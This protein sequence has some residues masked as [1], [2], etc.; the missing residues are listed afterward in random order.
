[1][2]KLSLRH[3]LLKKLSKRENID[4]DKAVEQMRE[5]AKNDP[6]IQKKFKEYNVPISDI[7]NVHIE[8]CDL[9]V[10]A[11]TKNMNIYINKK[12]LDK[13][14]KVK[15]PTHYLIHEL[16]HYLQQKTGKNSS[17]KEQNGE[18]YLDKPSEEEAFQT[19]LDYKKREESP[20]EAIEYVEDLLEYHDVDD[21]KKEEKKEE[22]LGDID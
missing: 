12:M 11:K 3:L 15:D 2:K 7:E 10:S 21:K 16:V 19:Q 22:L 1:M 4:Y 13:D 8:F 6:A 5:V 20:E 17:T 14:S 18:D 9:D